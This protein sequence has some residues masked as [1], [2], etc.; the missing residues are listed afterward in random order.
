MHGQET[1]LKFWFG[2]SIIWVLL[3]PSFVLQISVGDVNR[4]Q[5]HWYLGYPFELMKH[6]PMWITRADP[7]P[8]NGP[9]IIYILTKLVF[10]TGSLIP[11]RWLQWLFF[12]PA[13]GFLWTLLFHYENLAKRK[14][15]EVSALAMLCA[16]AWISIPQI[17][18]YHVQTNGMLL[19]A[20]SIFVLVTKES[21]RESFRIA[22]INST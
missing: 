8:E 5:E 1:K 15:V 18:L 14:L 20:L 13:T 21:I 12:L 19:S 11:I 3:T 10:E 17:A 2:L 16:F 6:G 4:L 9:H 22:F 7:F